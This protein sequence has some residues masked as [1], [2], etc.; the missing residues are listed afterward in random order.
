MMK[1]IYILLIALLLHSQYFGQDIHFVQTS[2][3]PILLNPAATGVFPGWERVSVA[4]RQQWFTLGSPYMTT[5]ISA[6]LN[7]FKQIQNKQKA[8]MGLGVNF[9]NDIAGDGKMGINQGSLLLS[10]IVNITE[11]QTISAGLE[12]GAAQQS[13][14]M[15]NLTWGSQFNGDGFD[16][17]IIAAEGNSAASL[18]YADIGAGIY[19]NLQNVTSTLSRKEVQRLYAGVSYYHINAP[20]REFYNGSIDQLARKFVGLAGAEIDIPNSKF[21]FAPSF[22]AIFQGPNRMLLGTLAAKFRVKDGTKYTGIYNNTYLN[23]GLN[24]RNADAIAPMV[25]MEINNYRFGI[26]YEFNISPLQASTNSQGSFEISFQWANFQTAMFQGRRT[27]GYKKPG[28]M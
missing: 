22:A 2:A 26:A 19:Y 5:Q 15:N 28:G 14:N 12:I 3:T 1:R 4:H 16:K 10:G 7:L 6:D 20:K 21:V 23:F 24:Y 18:V 13:I 11:D 27:K 25:G 9:F 8:H 17:D